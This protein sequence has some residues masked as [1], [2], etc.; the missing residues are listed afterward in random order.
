MP[1]ARINDGRT[2]TG[3]VPGIPG[4]YDGFD[5]DY[6]P[7]RPAAVYEHR[8]A[9]TTKTPAGELRADCEHVLA[10]LTG[11]NLQDDSGADQPRSVDTLQGLFHTALNV[12]LNH[13]NGYTVSE[14]AQA[15]N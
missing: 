7:A 4:L 2:L 15:K 8:R 6:R 5:F 13:V 10:H 9:A 14:D 1:S 12:M 11:W 3:T